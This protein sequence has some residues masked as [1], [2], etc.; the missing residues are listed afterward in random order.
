MQAETDD[1]FWGLWKNNYD[2]CDIEIVFKSGDVI[3]S[4]KGHSTILMKRQFFATRLV[5]YDLRERTTHTLEI[6]VSHLYMNMPISDKTV[7]SLMAFLYCGIKSLQVID[8]CSDLAIFFTL[9]LMMELQEAVLRCSHWFTLKRMEPAIMNHLWHVVSPRAK[10]DLWTNTKVRQCFSTSGVIN[11]E[12]TS[13]LS[14]LEGEY[15]ACRIL[16]NAF[17]TFMDENVF[18]LWEQ[19]DW[20][21]LYAIDI[22]LLCKFL[23]TAQMAQFSPSINVG[24]QWTDVRDTPPPAGVF[25][26]STDVVVETFVLEYLSA[27]DFILRTT[28]GE[29]VYAKIAE[30]LLSCIHYELWSELELRTF[31][32]L[33][34]RLPSTTLRDLRQRMDYMTC[35]NCFENQ[36]SRKP[37]FRFVMH[38]TYSAESS[39]VGTKNILHTP[40]GSMKVWCSAD[41]LHFF[42]Y[43]PIKPSKIKAWRTARNGLTRL[44]RCL[45]INAE[46][47]REQSLWCL[48]IS[49]LSSFSQLDEK[50]TAFCVKF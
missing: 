4:T 21:Q 44:Q 37:Q 42:L 17:L 38:S 22:E 10:S 48:K 40:F 46:T 13:H 3:T 24:K 2:K 26:I 27:E 5:Q 43:F 34:T 9:T 6:D 41:K 8:N 31:F 12:R 33:Y 19:K 16:Y 29:E 36:V 20:E 1:F 35:K 45:T 7:L 49:F 14:W 28:V 39:L 11:W 32:A 30:K 50:T 25:L 15:V 18:S 23:H 47:K